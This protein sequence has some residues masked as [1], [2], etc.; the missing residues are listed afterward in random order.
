MPEAFVARASVMIDAPRAKVLAAALPPRDHQA[1]GRWS[2][3]AN[4][5]I[6]DNNTTPRELEHS[7]G[8]WRLVLHNLKALPEGARE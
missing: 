3:D 2:A 7:A 4:L 1:F 5:G 8:G 6:Q